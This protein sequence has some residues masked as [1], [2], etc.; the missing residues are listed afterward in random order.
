[1]IPKILVSIF[2]RFYPQILTRN[3]NNEN[4]ALT[5]DDVPYDLES[6]KKILEILDKYQ[7]K[8]TFFIISSFVDSEE[9]KKLLID[10]V[11]NGHQL[12]NHGKTDSMHARKSID[13]L[14]N[15]ILECENLIKDIYCLA[16][17]KLS[18][19]KFYRPGCG[20]FNNQMLDLLC[21]LE[22]ILTLGS[23]YP[24]DPQI[25]FP[26]LNYYSLKFSIE[27]GDIIILHDR[28]WTPE[29]LELLLSEMTLKSVILNNII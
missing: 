8:A 4:I 26:K 20:F 22:Y 14:K 25:P 7:Q 17:V 10:A 3:K 2:E 11:K 15:E 12:A 27:K 29:M 24:F 6:F 23:V 1:M 13:E 16:D 28:K 21:E 5:F 19:K 18:D 9:K